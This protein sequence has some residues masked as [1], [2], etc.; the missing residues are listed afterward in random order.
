MIQPELD[1]VEGQLETWSRSSNPLIAEISRYVLQKK[2]KRLRPAL[3]LLSAKLFG[4]PGDEDIFLSSLME[5]IH[6][7]SL[8][9]DDIIDNAQTRRGR[10]SVHVRWGPNITVLLGDYLYIKSIGLALQSKHERIIQILSEI[11]SKMIEGELDEYASSG[12][13]KITEEEYLDIIG[14]KTAALFS[15]CCQIGAVLGQ[16][17]QDEERHAAEY[18]RNLGMCFQII[19]DLLDLTGDE[20]ILGKPILSDLTEGR[21]TL[22]LIHTLNQNGRIHSGFIT[23]LLH[24]KNIAVEEKEKLLDALASSNALDYTRAKAREFAENALHSLGRF[25]DSEFREMLARL[26]GFALLRNV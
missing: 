17:S 19:D 13:M 18:G 10:E 4:S 26:S 8:I 1:Q 5:L 23:S 11:S 22:P 7:A 12:N 6:T 24:R 15:G 9:H 21:L 25:P 20:K 16:A 2:G 3:V 14:K